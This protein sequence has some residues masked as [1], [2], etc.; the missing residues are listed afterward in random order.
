MR[1][2]AFLLALVCG[3]AAHG[4]NSNDHLELTLDGGERVDGWFVRAEADA[5]IVSVPG[6]PEPTRVPLA[7]LSEVTRNGRVQP[8]EQFRTEAGA[9]HEAWKSWVLHPPPHPPAVG[10]VAASLLVPGAGQAIL[11]ETDSAWGYLIAD[12]VFLGAGALELS[13][14]Q[15]LG[16]L[17]PLAGLSVL[18]RLTSASDAARITNR[19][20]RRLREARS[21]LMGPTQG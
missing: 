16:V 8:M 5:V 12:L 14:E 10:L 7:I 11:R 6:M 15:R 3:S 1:W 18:M 4:L 9:A 21:I 17:V 20:R 13:N 2:V 19:R